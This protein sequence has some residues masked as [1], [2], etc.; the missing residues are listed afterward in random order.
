[1]KLCKI[2]MWDSRS[3]MYSRLKLSS[4]WT[5]DEKGT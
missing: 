2:D 5:D 4:K 3:S 1:M